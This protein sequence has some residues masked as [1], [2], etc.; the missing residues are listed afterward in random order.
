MLR[1]SH[2]KAILRPDQS[3]TKTVSTRARSDFV[4]LHLLAAAAAAS[5]FSP[6]CRRL[7]AADTN[8]CPRMPVPMLLPTCHAQAAATTCRRRAAAHARIG[9]HSAS[10]LWGRGLVVGRGEGRI[11]PLLAANMRLLAMVSVVCVFVW[12]VCMLG[13]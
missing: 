9:V 5:P 7:S 2:D 6:M 3:L 4:W 13:V 11:P 1:L 8:H 12:S 10:S